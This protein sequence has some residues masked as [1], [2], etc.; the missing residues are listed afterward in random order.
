MFAIHFAT[1]SCKNIN[2]IIPLSTFS[3]AFPMHL[4]GNYSQFS[5]TSFNLYGDLFPDPFPD[6]SGCFYVFILL[7]SVYREPVPASF[8][9]HFGI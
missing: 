8:R 9:T 7:L 3:E 2:A 1:C 5:R 4:E 6:L